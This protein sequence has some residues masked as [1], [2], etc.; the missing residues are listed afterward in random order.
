MLKGIPAAIAILAIV[1]LASMGGVLVSAHNNNDNLNKSEALTVHEWGTFTTVAGPDGESANWLPLSGPN[2]LPCFVNHFQN[3][4]VKWSR[5]GKVLNYRDAREKLQ[6]KVRMETPVL[7]FYSPREENLNVKVNFSRGFVSEWYP[8]ANV[9]FSGNNIEWKQVRVVPDRKTNFPIEERPSHYYKARETDSNPLQRGA[10]K[11]KF[12]FY[13]GLGYFAVPLSATITESGK[14]RVRNTGNETMPV[15]VLFENQAGKIGYRIQKQFTGEA[16]FDAPTL[17]ADFRSLRKELE[18]ALLS[19]G[20]YEKEAHAMVETWRDSWFEEGTRVFYIL[21]GTT[22]DRL[23][24]LTIQPAPAH[25]ARAFV[26]RMEVFTPET[27]K[28]VENA[29]AANDIRTLAKYGRFLGSIADRI[30]AKDPRTQALLDSAYK[31]VLS[32]IA[33]NCK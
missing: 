8:A 32:E 28:T 7:Y 30:A 17:T 27:I 10:E 4:F 24:P 25:V 15:I 2:D 9:D 23:L 19:A 13:R 3:S 6:G 21:P 22:V 33:S 12:L 20:L 31:S 26:G 11:E 29:I 5:D 1:L 16:A 14:I 18:S